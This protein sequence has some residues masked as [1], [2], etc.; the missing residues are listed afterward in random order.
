VPGLW[1]VAPVG[2]AAC[3]YIMKGLPVRAWERFGIWMAV[4]V[5]LY[6]AYGFRHSLLR[7]R[8]AAPSTERTD[9]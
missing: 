6:F 4:G 9:G 7:R 8:G 1:I 2:A 5:L 3:V